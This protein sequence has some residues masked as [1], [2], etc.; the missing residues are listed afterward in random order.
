MTVALTLDELAARTKADPNLLAEV[1]ASEL[2]RGH[3]VKE[4]DRFRL[5]LPFVR[6]YGIVLRFSRP[7]EET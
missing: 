6:R 4:G 2:R 3:V 7:I 5:T 1:M